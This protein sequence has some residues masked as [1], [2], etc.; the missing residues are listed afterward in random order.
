MI[1]IFPLDFL[2]QGALLQP[3]N[4]QLHDLAVSYCA[5]ELTE[6]V[7]LSQ[8]GKV[9]IAAET[10]DET[11]VSVHGISGFV[12][13]PDIALFRATCDAATVK[14]HR[15]WHSHFADNGLLG[16]HVLLH[17]SSKDTAEQRCANWEQELIAAQA[18]AADRY[19]VKVRPF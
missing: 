10:Q 12:W 1:R 13:R 17:L 2:G 11:P 16:N 6:E 8:F 9:F 19:L 3:K 18:V 7:N 15:R 4:Q 5:K 14:L